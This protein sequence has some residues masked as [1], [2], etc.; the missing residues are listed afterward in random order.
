MREFERERNFYG[1]ERESARN[2]EESEGLLL[3][4]K[5][6]GGGSLRGFQI[7]NNL[8]LGGQLVVRI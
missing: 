7:S 3:V 2:R 4:L 1:N 5:W 6:R 8:R